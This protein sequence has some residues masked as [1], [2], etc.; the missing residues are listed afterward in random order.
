M[1]YCDLIGAATMIVVLHVR[2]PDQCAKHWGVA[3][4]WGVTNTGVLLYTGV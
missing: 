3:I 4:Y 2:S 1:K